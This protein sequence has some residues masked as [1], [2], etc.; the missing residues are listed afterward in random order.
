[1][2][3]VIRLEHEA[4]TDVIP[5]AVAAI[6]ECL[7]RISV[8]HVVHPIASDGPGMTNRQSPW[9]AP[10]TRRRCTR[11]VLGDDLSV[12]DVIQANEKALVGAQRIVKPREV[13]VQS[14]GRGCIE[15]ETA[16][17]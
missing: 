16:G 15:A 4:K 9:M 13:R 10:D 3:L 2:C 11:Q 12:T 1:M 7:A 5:A 17:I 6:R 8:P 14:D